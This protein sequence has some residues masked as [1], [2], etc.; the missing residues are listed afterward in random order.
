MNDN[1]FK[2]SIYWICLVILLLALLYSV[3]Q[4][5]KKDF[6]VINISNLIT[7]FIALF[8]TV[9][10]KTKADE[11]FKHKS[12]LDKLLNEI[13]DI[14]MDEYLSK[15]QDDVS[16][17]T[18]SML[19][20]RL[21]NKI[22]ILKIRQKDKNKINVSSD[23]INYIEDQLMNYE[24][25]IAENFESLEQLSAKEVSLKMYL[26]NIENRIDSI[27]YEIS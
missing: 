4:S 1:T 10:Y 3:Y 22:N 20:R 18:N 5:W 19:R 13:K 2:K 27:L 21:S 26:Y 8:F 14:L 25:V 17:K 7:L 9:I 16:K 23:D 6:F 15:I 24:M 12:I 11:K